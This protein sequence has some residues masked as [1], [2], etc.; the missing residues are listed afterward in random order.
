M[1]RTRRR[2]AADNVRPEVRALPAYAISEAAADVRLDRNE[3]PGEI[4]PALRSAILAEVDSR[5]WSRYPDPYARE[6]KAIAA[7]SEGLPPD[8][9][10]AGNGSNSLFLSLF[11]AVGGSGRRFAI[12]PPTFSLYAP[13]LKATGA[14]ICEFPVDEETLEP[15]ATRLVEAARSDPDLSF[16]LCSPNNPTGIP[17]PRPA[18]VD[19]LETGALVVVDEAYA[20][21][22]GTSAR[23]LLGLHPNLVI[24]RTLSKAAALAGVRVGFLFGHPD[25]LAHVE[26]LV[27]PYSVNLFARA[28]ASA[29]LSAPEEVRQRVGAIV[30]ERQRMLAAVAPVPGARVRPSWANF[31]YLRTERPASEVWAELQRRGVLVRKVAG[32]PGDALRVTVGRPEENDAFVRAWSEV[33]A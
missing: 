25:L 15:P 33:M 1:S 20:E 32:T 7:A 28:A 6:L 13:W 29:V 31:L 2:S 11:A 24:A 8:R 9:V 16:V 18:L 19:L 10:L 21:F 14:A 27:P 22:S 4:S 17:F 12:A 23:D 26:K 5:R 30:A 3:S